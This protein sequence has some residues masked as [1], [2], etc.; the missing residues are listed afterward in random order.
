MGKRETHFEVLRDFTNKTLERQLAD[1]ELGGLLVTSDFT[2]RNGSR[3]EPV[4]LLDTT[5]GGLKTR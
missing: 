1:K 3:P 4:G 2:E 5:G